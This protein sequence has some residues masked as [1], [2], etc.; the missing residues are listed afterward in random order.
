MKIWSALILAPIFQAEGL[1]EYGV[2]SC[3]DL[4]AITSPIT[5]DTILSFTTSPI[6]CDSN[7]NM[8]IRNGADLTL[9][10]ALEA[11]NLVNIRFQVEGGSTLFVQLPNLEW[12]SE[13]TS[14]DRGGAAVYLAEPFA[15]A[16]FD[17]DVTFTDCILPLDGREG[18]AIANMGGKLV[19]EKSVSIIGSSYGGG[20]Y[21]EG[22]IEFHGEA[23]FRDN[24]HLND[25]NNGGA[26]LQ[27]M[28]GKI[29][30]KAAASFID[31]ET[32]DFEDVGAFEGNIY[33]GGEGGGIHMSTDD[34]DDI[35]EMVFEG[36]VLFSGNKAHSG[37]GLYVTS[38]HDLSTVT[39]Q[40]LVAFEDNQAPVRE[41]TGARDIGQVRR[42]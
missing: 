11:T 18:G 9:K 17:E 34:P 10:T 30:F 13:E 14:D 42:G 15:N 39:F 41:G 4:V 26:G 28:G 6:S 8:V 32:S 31:N 3:D 7:E 23:L 33:Y 29:T 40:D 36:P 20:L 5:E 37:A 1:Q 25:D 21:N 24:I 19:F 22:D 12:Q 38:S 35:P 16:F 27:T 2:G